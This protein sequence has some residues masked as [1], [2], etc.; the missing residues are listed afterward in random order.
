MAR[1]ERGNE[2]GKCATTGVLTQGPEGT[3]AR[4]IQGFGSLVGIWWRQRGRESKD[5]F[6]LGFERLFDVVVKLPVGSRSLGGIQIA[7][8]HDMAVGGIEVQRTCDILKLWEREKLKGGTLSKPDR[9]E[10]E[11]GDVSPRRPG[12]VNL[13]SSS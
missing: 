3:R 7:S 4:Q 10:R 6:I 11:M 2:I 12:D 1:I 9:R 13:P 8:T 5:G